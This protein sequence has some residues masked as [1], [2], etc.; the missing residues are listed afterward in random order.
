MVDIALVSLLLTLNIYLPLDRDFWQFL[1][2]LSDSG[3]R[4]GA[5]NSRDI[6]IYWWNMFSS[7]KM[8]ESSLFSFFLKNRILPKHLGTREYRF[9]ILSIALVNWK[10]FKLDFCFLL[11]LPDAVEERTLAETSPLLEID[12]IESLCAEYGVGSDDTLFHEC[13]RKGACKI[14]IELLIYHTNINREIKEGWASVSTVSPHFLVGDG[15][16][17]I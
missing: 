3:R 7:I 11:E 8:G 1:C 10:Y 12:F 6:F 15:T 13:N 16:S 14:V 17:E 9:C 4:M 2:V 5:I